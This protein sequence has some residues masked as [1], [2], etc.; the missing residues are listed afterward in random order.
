MSMWRPFVY[1]ELWC[2]EWNA[3][4]T[5]GEFYAKVQT[6]VS[7]NCT[8]HPNLSSPT[9]AFCSSK[10][11]TGIATLTGIAAYKLVTGV[12]TVPKSFNGISLHKRG[13][14]K[15]SK[16]QQRIS[17]VPVAIAGL[18]PNRFATTILPSKV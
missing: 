14:L 9:I 3:Q 15:Y 1:A 13:S 5:M 2:V 17:N 4:Q 8:F 6:D 7:N 10:H 18:V 12:S 16:A 11:T